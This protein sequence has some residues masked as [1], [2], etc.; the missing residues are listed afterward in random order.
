MAETQ[1]AP[2]VTPFLLQRAD[3]MCGRRLARAFEGGERS[4]DP[5]HRSRLRDAFLAAARDAHAELRAPTAADF[6]GMGAAL[7]PELLPEEQAVLT[8]AAHWYAQIFGERVRRGG[9]TR[10]PTSRRNGGGVRVGG[11]IDL[12]VRTADGGHE[13]RQ[14]ELWGRRVAPH[15]PLDL[16]ALRTAFLRLDALARRQPAA[17]GLGRPPP[18]PRAGAGRRTGRPPRG[19]RVVRPPARDRAR[20]RRRARHDHPGDDCGTCAVVAACPEHRKGAHYGRRRDLLPGILHVTPTNLD[21]WRRCPREWRNACLFG[22]PSSDTDPGTVHGQQM[23]DVLR[24][25][26]ERGTCRDDA[27]VDDVLVSHGFDDNERMRAELARHT[28]RCPTPAD[29]LGHEVTRARFGAPPDRAVHGHRAARRA[30]G[31]RRH[32]RRARLQDRPRV[33]RPRRRRLAGPAAGLGGRT[34]R[35]ARSGSALRITFEHLATEVLDDP[36]PFEPDA[37]DLRAIEDE[38]RCEVVA[39][40]SEVDFAGVADADVCH[41]CRYRSICPDSAVAGVPVWPVVEQEEEAG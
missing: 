24:L 32:P 33:D 7:Q 29:A 4:H 8:Q 30:V 26:H 35:R 17:R 10:A 34:A 37:D 18:R 23:H 15:E 9:T 3:T 40:R 13:L 2:R 1:V 12:P 11:W 28:A 31:A 6:D 16:P 5:V 38:L 25:V 22:I 21:T 39:I 14:V 20:P 41:R 19:H 27:H 36:E